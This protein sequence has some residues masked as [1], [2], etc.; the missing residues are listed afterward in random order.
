MKYLKIIVVGGL[1]ASLLSNYI[2]FTKLDAMDNKINDVSNYQHQ[3]MNTVNS[4][5]G[6]MNS[7]INKIKEDQS[8]LSAVKVD[9]VMDES[10]KNKAMVNFEWQVKELQNNSEVLFNYKKNEE[11]EYKPIKAVDKGNGFFRV[12]MPTE[13]NPE[14]NWNYQII[15]RGS[16]S[17]EKQMRAIEE[18]K[19]AYERETQLSFDYYIS[20]SH[21][22]MIK[23][24][25]INNA[26]IEDIGARYYGYLE[27]RTDIDKDKNFSLSVMNGKM[28]DSSIYLK[29]ALLKKYRDGKLIAEEK[30]EERKIIYEGGMPAG[31]DTEEFQ[32]KPSEEKFD[33]SSLVLKVVYNDGSVFEKEVYGK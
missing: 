15:D 14:P 27:V 21:G 12:V 31:E 33:Y 18:K 32:T 6:T 7:S 9:T 4:Q 2:L 30:L 8:W 3:V 11:K 1:C 19:A 23:S 28:Y 24:G 13:I 17:I 26:R 10:N 5:V 20:V 16:K 25:E 22:D 29:E